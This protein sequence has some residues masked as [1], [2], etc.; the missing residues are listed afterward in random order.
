MAGGGKM[1]A[2]HSW[3]KRFTKSVNRTIEE[4]TEENTKLKRTI[5]FLLDMSVSDVTNALEKDALTLE[6]IKQR[7]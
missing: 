3:P 4:L 6:S 7:R 1:K 5:A 2:E